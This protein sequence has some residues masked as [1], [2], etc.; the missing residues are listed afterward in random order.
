MRMNKKVTASMAAL[1]LLTGCTN[2]DGSK[3]IS[4]TKTSTN[5]QNSKKEQAHNN[6]NKSNNEQQ[7]RST[8]NQLFISS[9]NDKLGNT[10][11][12]KDLYDFKFKKQNSH[13]YLYIDENNGSINFYVSDDVKGEHLIHLDKNILFKDNKFI[14]KDHSDFDSISHLIKLTNGFGGT[15]MESKIAIDSAYTSFTI[16]NKEIKVKFPEELQLS[17]KFFVNSANNMVYEISE[18]NIEAVFDITNNKPIFI[19]GQPVKLQTENGIKSIAFDEKGNVYVLEG[20]VIGT[21][22]LT[23]YDKDL[24]LLSDKYRIPVK[25]TKFVGL[26]S[27]KNGVSLYGVYPS[28]LN[29]DVQKIELTAPKSFKMIGAVQ[30]IVDKSK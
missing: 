7:N 14:R 15:N 3:P 4:Q 30:P 27:G 9:R 17:S 8:E 29:A 2:N 25:N 24:N 21:V 23:V 10:S 1:L 5:E 26:T 16:N 28:K 13:S 6:S 19:D 22:D 18:S 20:G 12:P 11:I